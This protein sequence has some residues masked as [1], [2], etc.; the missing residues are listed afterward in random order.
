MNR[1]SVSC[2][3]FTTKHLAGCVNR[4]MWFVGLFLCLI[5]AISM[6]VTLSSEEDVDEPEGDA[7]AVLISALL[8]LLGGTIFAIGING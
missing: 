4:M 7:V 3:S 1:R 2:I 6:A 8:I 5:G